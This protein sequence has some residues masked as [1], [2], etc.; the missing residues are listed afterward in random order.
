MYRSFVAIGDSFTEGVGD[1]IGPDE[2]RGWADRLA[3]AFQEAQPSTPF[4]YANLAIRGRKLK[5]LLQEQIPE[6]VA[7]RPDLISV[8]GGGNDMLR[9]GFDTDVALATMYPALNYALKAGIHVLLLAG[10]NPTDNIPLGS[11]FDKRAAEFTR[12][13]KEWADSIEGLTFVDNFNDEG[14]RDTTYWS[15]DGL[16]L[17]AA[18]HLRVAANCADAL[19]LPYPKSWG[20]PRNPEPDPKTYN[21]FGYYREH[22]LPWIGRRL[23]GRSSGDGR[24]AKRPQLEPLI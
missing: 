14:F 12:R 5:Q 16:H 10:P 15:E 9:P 24:S 17:S 21:S 11:V 23:T 19:G 6:A 8:N 18:G 1:W 13:T 2:P 4:Q 3:E 22:I 20:D 7:Q